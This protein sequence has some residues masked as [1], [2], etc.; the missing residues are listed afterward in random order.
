MTLQP[1][2][3]LCFRDSGGGPLWCSGS[4]I[5]DIRLKKD[6]SDVGPVLD[7]I[8]KLNVINFRYKEGVY[9]D[10]THIGLVAQEVEKEFPDFVYPDK[11][12]RKLVYYDKVS[13]ILT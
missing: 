11:T 3:N 8:D 5:S 13:N 10:K 12:G 4:S 6:I 1:D 7:K 2:G 9:D